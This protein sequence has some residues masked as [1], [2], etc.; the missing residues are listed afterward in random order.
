MNHIPD[1]PAISLRLMV[2]YAC[3]LAAGWTTEISAIQPTRWIHTTEADFATGELDHTMVTN[4]GDL[5]LAPQVKTIGR[6][7]RK[8]TVIY[9]LQTVDE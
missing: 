8:A 2:I 9:D 5:K 1:D 6:T 7:P 4:L 3:L